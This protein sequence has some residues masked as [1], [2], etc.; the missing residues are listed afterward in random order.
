MIT[1]QDVLDNFE[2]RIEYL[3]KN[4]I[5]NK[6]VDV[7]RFT[8]EFIKHFKNY[9]NVTPIKREWYSRENIRD[10]LKYSYLKIIKPVSK[11]ELN[12]DMAILLAVSDVFIIEFFKEF[13]MFEKLRSV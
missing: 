7:L 12:L 10:V 9:P 3:V 8:K 4:G 2:P 13:L 1:L 11:R 5:L 6:E